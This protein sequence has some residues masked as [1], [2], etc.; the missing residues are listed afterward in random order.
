[1]QPIF[2]T[3]SLS[4]APA[5][6]QDAQE[7]L[8]DR[9]VFEMSISPQSCGNFGPCAWELAVFSPVLQ[10]DESTSGCVALNGGKD[11]FDPRV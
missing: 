9:D 4:L 6:K 1:V 2:S 8:H 11:G 5:V 3:I 7:S 10:G